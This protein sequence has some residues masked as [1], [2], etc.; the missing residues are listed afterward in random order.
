MKNIVCLI[1]KNDLQ[2]RANNNH[3]FNSVIDY[4]FNQSYPI[5]NILQSKSGSN[6]RLVNT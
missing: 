5:T 4:Y 2:V 3:L 1:L 6:Y